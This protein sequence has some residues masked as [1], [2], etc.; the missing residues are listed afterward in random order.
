M[1]LAL[2]DVRKNAG[3]RDRTSLP[4]ILKQGR[5]NASPEVV[6]QVSE[7]FWEFELHDGQRRHEWHE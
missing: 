4:W 2:V 3:A 6:K 7:L 5:A 1:L